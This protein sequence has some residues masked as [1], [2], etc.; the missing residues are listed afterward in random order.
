MATVVVTHGGGAHRDEFLACAMLTLK[1]PD[2]HIIRTDDP[3]K[4]AAADIVVDVGG[5]YDPQR[6]RYDHHHDIS[7]PCSLIMVLQHEY[8]ITQYPLSVRFLDHADRFGIESARTKYNVAT[9]PNLIEN[10]VLNSFTEENEITSGTPTA[11]LLKYIARG[12]HDEIMEYYE[13]ATI[14]WTDIGN[15]A[16]DYMRYTTPDGVVLITRDNIRTDLLIQIFGEAGEKIIGLIKPNPRGG[17]FSIIS[18]N[19]NPAFRPTNVASF[20]EIFTH[21]TGFMRVIDASWEDIKRSKYRLLTEVL[22]N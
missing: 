15:E 22:T 8:F 18:I 10:A 4:I 13:A 19:N 12:I 14:V 16:S 5:V 20:P 21:K 2:I 11:A 1:Y 17:G 9:A 3:S 7:L 6:K